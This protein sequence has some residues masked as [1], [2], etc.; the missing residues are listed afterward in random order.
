MTEQEWLKSEDP[1]RMLNA[2][3]MV[4]GVRVP[5]VW[6]G[7]KM[8]S[9]RKL[10]LFAAACCRRV[11]HLLTDERSRRAV[12]VAERYADGEATKGELSQACI[13]DAGDACD[14]LD[15]GS[16]LC[17]H[18]ASC[19]NLYWNEN[20][21]ACLHSIIED[22][23]RNVGS[24]AV[25]A[26]LRDIVGNPFRPV[27][28]LPGETVKCRE[29]GGSGELCTS[30]RFD[31]YECDGKGEI[32]T[33]CPWL[34]PTVLSLAQAAY[35]LRD[36][37]GLLEDDRLA[38]LSDALEEAGCPAW[39]ECPEC[40]GTGSVEDDGDGDGWVCA[41]KVNNPILAALRSPGPHVRGCWVVD[42]LLGKE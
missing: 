37:N 28:L 41:V 5:Q 18:A 25:A 34:T 33:P 40:G 14:E 16:T 2:F 3:S 31:C 1:A 22:I 7:L 32:S 13:D 9:D 4:A 21:Q 8:P 24:A 15:W 29:C 10:R 17:G 36:G 30:H 23:S 42:L 26:L 38:V 39:V 35:D 20:R 12:E 6:T 27:V 19:V 11:W